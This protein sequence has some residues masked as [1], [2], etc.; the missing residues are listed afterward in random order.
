ML[1][2]PGWPGRPQGLPHWPYVQAV[3][4]ALA[5]HG[6]PPGVVRADCT[7]RD[8]GLTPYMW[9]TWDVS[10][11]GGHGGIRLHWKERQGWFYALIGLSPRDVYLYTVLTPFRT[12]FPPPQDVADVAEQ[13]V[14]F[15]RL[16]DVEHREEWDGAEEVRAAG[17]DF[18]RAC[19]GLT[20]V[21]QQ[22][23]EAG[24]R[25]GS[26]NRKGEGV[27][28][29]IDTQTD[30][31]EQAIAAVRAAYGRNLPAPAVD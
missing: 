26:E 24:P 15:R 9:L 13:M 17:R 12:V 3:D 20:P 1:D 31:Y 8:D 10:C 5:A 14:R 22:E 30:T 19:F 21:G 23:S 11:T 7:T 27:Q 25:S 29:T 18:R 4:E 2:P 6:I 28:L 16:P